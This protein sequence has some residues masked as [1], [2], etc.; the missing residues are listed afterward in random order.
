MKSRDELIREYEIDISGLGNG[1]HKIKCPQCQPPR[2]KHNSKDRP[3]SVTIRGDDFVFKCHH[4]EWA[5]GSGN[6][7][8]VVPIVR[9]SVIVQTKAP[10]NFLI[11]YFKGRGISE[12]T[13]NAFKISATD[14]KWIEFP[15]N[16]TED[17]TADNIKSRTVDKQFRQLK[18][19]KKSL[20][21]YA[22]VQQSKAV[23]WV[24]GEVDVL[25]CWEAGI[26]AVTTLPDGAPANARF[27][28][29][30]KRFEPLQTHPL[31]RCEKLVIFVDN[32]NAGQ[33]LRK[34]LLHRFGKAICWYVETP[35][36]C[37]DA[38]DVLV[39][40]GPKRLVDL[41]KD[42]KPYPV[43][44]LYQAGQ[45]RSQ[46]ADLYHGNYSKPVRIGLPG[47][48]DI[49]RVQ[50]GTFHC[51]TGVPN[52]GKSTFLDQCLVSLARH[53]AWRF[54]M[55]SP[56]HSVPMHIRRLSQIVQEK[57]FDEGYVGR[58]TED[59]MNQAVKWINGHFHFIET[60][61]HTPNVEKLLEI[62]KGA[63]KKY[64]VNGIVIDPYNEVDATRT[65]SYREDEHIRDFISRCKRFCRTHDV[66]IWIVAHP[67]KMQKNISTGEYEP[68]TAYDI[69][70]AAHWHNQS[71]AVLVVHRDF[72]NDSVRVITRKIREQG[73]Y[74]KIGEASF[75]YNFKKCIFEPKPDEG[76]E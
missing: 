65:G 37:K 59:E 18:G 76:Y 11:D 19:A 21:N 23:L 55:F 58:M 69:S 47:L 24:E 31:E 41:I 26:K 6:S 13:V 70:G 45:Y 3:L 42:A 30:D 20:Y 73:F 75:V 72:D 60:K 74:G 68:P 38:N 61:E 2:G 39:K 33:N 56:E 12:S 10:S 36:G 28:E 16:P 7:N 32:D 14:N 8:K 62:A 48:D 44:G 71:D 52:H 54:A 5:G 40:H 17:N 22:S 43:D 50:K 25:S 51:V 46:V 9:R 15:Y 35:E 53:E 29:N 34:E 4:C 1:D 27:K 67:K 63:V 49:Y 66:V 64:G 57:H